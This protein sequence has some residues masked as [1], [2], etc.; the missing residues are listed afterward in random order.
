MFVTAILPPGNILADL[1]NV[2]TTL[3]RKYG[4]T[5]VHAFPPLIPLAVSSDAPAEPEWHS[6]YRQPGRIELGKLESIDGHIVIPT[7]DNRVLAAIAS[8]LPN[9]RSDDKALLPIFTLYLGEIEDLPLREIE[10]IA[11][12]A[13][14]FGIGWKRSSLAGLEFI[15]SA[16]EEWWN[17]SELRYLWNRTLKSPHRTHE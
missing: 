12:E 8:Q 17:G 15:P 3:F 1:R 7:R 13:N 5:S 2:K 10:S 4:V 14:T 9:V 6:V 11:R 16:H